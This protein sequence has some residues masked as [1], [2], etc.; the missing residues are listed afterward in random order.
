MVFVILKNGKV[1]Q[2]NGAHHYFT[3]PIWT[4]IKVGG[5]DDN[6]TLASIPTENIERVEFRHPCQVMKER[7]IQPRA[8]KY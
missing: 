8:A 5:G 1:L 2:Y 7:K 4:D 3:G 6:G